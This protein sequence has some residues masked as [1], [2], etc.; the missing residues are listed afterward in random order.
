MKKKL[1]LISLIAFSI[2]ANSQIVIN[3]IN[4]K[5]AIDFPT[6]DW[7]ELYNNSA[8]TVDISNWVFKDNDDLHEFIIPSG[9]TMAPGS[10]LVLTQFLADFQA[11]FPGASPVIGDFE[12]GLSGGG[13]LIRL[14]NATDQLVDFVEYSDLDPWPTEPDGNGPT[15]ELR[16]PD[17]DNNLASS[18]SGSLVSSAPHGTPCQ[19]NSTY[20]LGT[21]SFNQVSF[22]ISPNPLT[23]ST[24]IKISNSNNFHQLRIYDV[25]GKLIKTLHITSNEFIL[26]K[27]N[28]E[29]GIYMLNIYSENGSFQDSKKLIVK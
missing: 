10:Y 1:L 11:L 8:T 12:F 22:S 19:Q 27:E 7:I 2:N 16:N 17:L 13:E 28:L 25:L 18:W 15:L 26:Q 20:V 6:K 3:E 4:Y 5:D 23:N 9:T 21:T 29:T 14:Y 24:T